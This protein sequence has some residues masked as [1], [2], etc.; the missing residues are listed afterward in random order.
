MGC[1]GGSYIV[2]KILFVL[3]RWP[4]VIIEMLTCGCGLPYDAN[5]G[6]HPTQALESTNLPLVFP[7]ELKVS[8][9][10]IRVVGDLPYAPI[11]GTRLLHSKHSVISLATDKGFQPDPTAT[12]VQFLERHCCLRDTPL[13]RQFCVLTD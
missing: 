5:A 4:V 7:P 10:V 8:T 6:V 11:F 1:G 3:R 13:A 12:S 2:F 9:S